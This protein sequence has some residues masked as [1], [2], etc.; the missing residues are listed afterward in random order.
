MANLNSLKNRISVVKNTSKITNA[1]QLVSTAK[2]R[3]IKNE[4][5]SIDSYLALLIDTF[6]ELIYH[7]Q[8]EDFYSIFPK[9]NNTTAKLYIVI[10]SDLGLCGSYNTNV[11]NLL[12]SKIQPEDQIIVIGT[13]GYSLLHSSSLKEQ[14]LFKYLNYGEKVSYS[15]ANEITK[16]VLEMYA[17]GKISAIELIYTKFVN[18]I[19]QEAV[20]KQLFPLEIQRTKETISQDIEFEPNSEVVLKN[21]IPLYIGSLIYC[22]GSSSKISEMASRRNAMENATNNANDLSGHLHLQFNR[23]RQRVITQEINEIVAGADAT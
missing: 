15:I 12:K 22:L 20:S 4:F 14:I 18:N 19:T 13:K 23:E 21:S 5:E 8:P 1:M 7:V 10:T 9:N 2:L 17:N 6:D 16:K 11:I 3:R